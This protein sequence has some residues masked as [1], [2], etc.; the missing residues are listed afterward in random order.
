MVEHWS[1]K[2]GVGS[3]SLSACA[4]ETG[5]EIF[6]PI[7]S[8]R[9]APA[10]RIFYQ[11]KSLTFFTILVPNKWHRNTTNYLFSLYHNR[12]K[13][14]FHPLRQTLPIYLPF[15]DIFTLFIN[16]YPEHSHE[17]TTPTYLHL[18]PHARYSMYSK[19]ICPRHSGNMFFQ[20]LHIWR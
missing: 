14:V 18:L 19:R 4:I 3:S 9:R 15:A 17:Q 5:L 2:P 10:R 8:F 16:F 7:Q 1:P 13:P 12:S 6:R 20:L 11:K